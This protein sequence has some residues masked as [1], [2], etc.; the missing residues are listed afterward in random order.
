MIFEINTCY[1]GNVK[2]AGSDKFSQK[3]TMCARF[4]DI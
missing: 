1:K 4:T 2:G 3:I